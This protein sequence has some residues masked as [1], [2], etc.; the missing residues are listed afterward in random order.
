MFVVK[1]G[2]FIN[3]LQVESIQFIQPEMI[4]HSNETLDP[5]LVIKMGS[6]QEFKVTHKDCDDINK[7]AEE[8]VF[9]IDI[10]TGMKIPKKKK[11]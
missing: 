4:L 7:V 6:G 11:R 9:H 5:W 3:P 10:S 1:P 2:V 8:L